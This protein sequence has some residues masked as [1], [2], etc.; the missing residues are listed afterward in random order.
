MSTHRGTE[1]SAMTEQTKLPPA[2]GEFMLYQGKQII[3]QKS[4]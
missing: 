2:F 4:T 3:N 1:D